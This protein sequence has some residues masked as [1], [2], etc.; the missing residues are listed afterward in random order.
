MLESQHLKA[1]CLPGQPA[2]AS[3]MGQVLAGSK[4]RYTPT[5]EHTVPAALMW[6]A[7]GSPPTLTFSPAPNTH[8]SEPCSGPHHHTQ[9]DV[10]CQLQQLNYM[11]LW[12]SIV[13]GQRAISV[14]SLISC[15]LTLMHVVDLSGKGVCERVRKMWAR[16]ASEPR[17]H[18]WVAAEQPPSCQ[19]NPILQNVAYALRSGRARP[20]RRAGF[21]QVHTPAAAALGRAHSLR[22]HKVCSVPHVPVAGSG[23]KGV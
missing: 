13:G 9:D 17:A 14:A 6:R 5:G 10:W 1:M 21:A 4:V 19:H 18:V 16:H 8:T 20:V 11:V 23:R 2:P 22:G 12:P 3:P 7:R 15:V